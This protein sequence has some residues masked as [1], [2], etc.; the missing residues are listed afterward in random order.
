MSGSDR[1][2]PGPTA[3][4]LAGMSHGAH[5]WVGPRGRLQIERRAIDGAEQWVVLDPEGVVE[6]ASRLDGLSPGCQ[7]LAEELGLNDPP[8]PGY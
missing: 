4:E 7:R 5:A 2:E 1:D 6:M 3:G 8:A